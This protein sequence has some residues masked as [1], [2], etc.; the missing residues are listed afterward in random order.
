MRFSFFGAILV[1]ALALVLV[2]PATGWTGQQDKQVVDIEKALNPIGLSTETMKSEQ[3][4]EENKAKVSTDFF[5]GIRDLWIGLLHPA[6]FG[7]EVATLEAKPVSAA[8]ASEGVDIE[9]ALNPIGLSTETAKSEQYKEE[10]KA[11]VSTEFFEGI[12]DLWIGLLHPAQF[13]ADMARMP[14]NQ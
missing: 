11:M 9:K 14:K 8:P 6:K 3:Y 13:G 4:K 5:E 10:N 2:L 7:K 1:V 12:R